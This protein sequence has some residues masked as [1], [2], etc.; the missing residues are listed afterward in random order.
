MNTQPKHDLETGDLRELAEIVAK[1]DGISIGDLP[2]ADPATDDLRGHEPSPVT[3]PETDST[4]MLVGAAA[5]AAL[6]GALGVASY[7]TGMWNS[8]PPAL[9]P[10]VAAP[11]S[12]PAVEMQQAV[13]PA[14]PQQAVVPP[15]PPVQAVVPPAAPVQAVRKPVAKRAAAPAVQAPP[16]PTP[17]ETTPIETTPPEPPMN[18][19]LAP[20]PVEPVPTPT[21]P[22]LPQ[23]SLPD[24]PS[25][26][27]QPAPLKP[28]EPPQ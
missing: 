20:A 7:A 4:R 6:I 1:P 25:A 22:A 8:A 21:Q 19:T 11:L 2:N 14:P 12:V 9:T 23:L 17:P 28:T 27:T 13:V 24:L 3:N 16:K 15:A 10:R 26:P 18:T 5:V